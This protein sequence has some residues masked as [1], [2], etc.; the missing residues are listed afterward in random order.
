MM[1]LANEAMR[2]SASLAIYHAISNP[3]RGRE[4]ILGLL[5]NGDECVTKNKV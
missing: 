5:A 3:T 2:H 1:I 4:I